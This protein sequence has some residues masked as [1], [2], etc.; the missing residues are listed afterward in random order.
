MNL[1]TKKDFRK[2]VIERRD[3]LTIDVKNQYDDEIIA[4][5]TA[6]DEYI[7]AET[8]FVFVSFGSEADT[9]RFIEKAL[10]AGKTICVPK[11]RTKEQGIEVFKIDSLS[12]LCPG[13]YGILEPAEGCQP[14]ASDSI[15][16]I[17]MPGVAFDRNGGRIGYGAGYYDRYLAKMTKMVSKIALC[18]NFQLFKNVPIDEFDIRIDGVITNDEVIMVEA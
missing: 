15:D 3:S 8:I 13:Y 10:K 6:S 1:K 16:L 4:K 11:I 7:C 17:L 2:Y 12:D 5:L 18:Y 9:H 14:V